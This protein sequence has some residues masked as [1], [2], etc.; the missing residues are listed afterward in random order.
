[1]SIEPIFIDVEATL[2]VEIQEIGLVYKEDELK[3]SSIKE[4]SE[5]IGHIPTNYIAG[6]NIIAFDKQIL[7]TSSIST[8]LQNKTF[9]DTLPVSLLL[10]N[11]K[12]FHNLPKNYKSED[13][14][15]NNPVKDA[16]LSKELLLRS[17]EK[18]K[19][20]PTL[21]RNILY[22]LLKNEELFKGFFEFIAHEKIFEELSSIILQGSILNIFKSIIK[23]PSVLKEALETH[24]IELAFI[25]AIRM[26]ELEVNAQPPKVLYDYKE[27]TSLQSRLCFDYDTS[28]DELSSTA[29]DI[30]GF[31][32]FRDFPRQDATLETGTT[33]SQKEIV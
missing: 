11:E 8:L 14:F 4:A 24:R 26:P 31:G 16:K 19:T 7:D 30:F 22:T 23:N 1:M 13:N 2:N 25:L 18:F 20:L 5:F 27:I 29:K 3:T 15:L 9:I 21:Q 32:T 17:I 33:I 10:F 6:H 12:T 28:I